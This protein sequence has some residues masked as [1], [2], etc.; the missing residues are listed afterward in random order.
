MK[1]FFIFSLF[2]LKCDSFLFYSNKKYNIINA[3]KKNIDKDIYD[4]YY[5]TSKESKKVFEYNKKPLFKART[6]KQTN[7]YNDICDEDIKIVIASGPAG[8]GK[9]LFPTQHVATLL[10]NPEVKVVFTRPLISVDE[11]LGYL[12]G[13]INQ[14][15]DPWI[16]P[17]FDVLREFYTQKEINYFIAEKKIEIVPL[18]FMRGRTFK[19]TFIIGDELQNTSN[20]QLLML[21]TRLGE[22]SKMVITGDINQCDNN[23]N[24]LKDL[25]NKINNNYC[26]ITELR[27]KGISL[28]EFTNNDIQRSPIIETILDIYNN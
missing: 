23:E 5:D 6:E 1:F 3:R 10:K 8:T 7:Y 16:I 25:L 22:N 15:M 28:I 27:K 12:P 19:N 9:T 13:D 11:E 18:A 4:D 2:L 24:G 26:N 21:L 20:R 17:I 14:K